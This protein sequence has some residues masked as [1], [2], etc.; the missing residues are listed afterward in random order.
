NN[1]GQEKF[2]PFESSYIVA[3]P[4]A[5]VS[6]TAM[7][8]FYKGVDN[9]I[10]LSVPGVPI[11]QVRATINGG[12]QIVSQGGGDYIVKLRKESPREGS[13]TVQAELNGEWT[14]MS[15]S[16]FR[17]LRLPAP[18]ARV[19]NITTGGQMR[20]S[21]LV[22]SNLI[23]E[24]EKGFPLDIPK[25]KLKSFNMVYAGSQMKQKPSC[26]SQRLDSYSEWLNSLSPGGTVYIEDILI[27]DKAGDL[28]ELPPLK[29]KILR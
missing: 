21:E 10:N 11:D 3:Q 18:K 27:E 23:L 14:T 4:T 25:P 13:V 17:V 9:P 1:S 29:I 8:V 16:K 12:N 15:V 28:L 26:T 20:K 2:F 24:Y 6:A 19:K 22:Y 7:N 5:T